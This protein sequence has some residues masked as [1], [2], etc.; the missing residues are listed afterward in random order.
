MDASCSRFRWPV[1]L[2]ALGALA[3]LSAGGQAAGAPQG[4]APAAQ[5][6]AGR[7]MAKIATGHPVGPLAAGEGAVWVKNRDGTVTRIDPLSNSVSATIDGSFP[8]PDGTTGWIAAG[9]GGVWTTNAAQ[10]SVTRIDPATNAVVATIPVGDLPTG[11]ALTPGAVWVANHHG[12]SL[13]RIDPTTNTVVSTIP[14]G[15][16]TTPPQRGPQELAVAGGAVWFKVLESS[17]GMVER[18]DPSTNSVVAKIPLDG[19]CSFGSDGAALWLGCLLNNELYHVDLAANALGTPIATPLPPFGL[20]IGLD[21]V[22]S[23]TFDDAA[24]HGIRGLVRSDPATGATVGVTTFAAAGGVTV[25]YG[26]V[27]TGSEG[28]QVLRVEP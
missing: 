28:G 3:A 16:A 27:W 8:I 25:G 2:L 6:K 22:W 13:S 9:N 14:V 20:A 19:P 10:D 24:Y 11:V 12:R 7:I 4:A 21:A 5:P 17:G 23:V 26:A 18:L 1:A 15:D